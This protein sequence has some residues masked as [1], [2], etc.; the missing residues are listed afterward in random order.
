MRIAITGASGLIGQETAQLL[1][2]LGHSIL[3][4]GRDERILQKIFTD[5]IDIATTN[6]EVEDLGNKLLNIDAI[7]HLA[8][9]RQTNIEQDFTPYIE[10]NLILTENLLK[11]CRRNNIQTFC[12]TSGIAVYSEKNTSPYREDQQLSP[13]NPYGISKLTA[14]HLINM[15]MSQQ[16]SR[17]IILRLPKVFGAA[18]Q[19]EKHFILTRFIS[20]AIKKRETGCL[21]NRKNNPRF[22]LCERHCQGNCKSIGN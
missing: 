22:N 13:D 2:S 17:S 15:Y 7:V 10:G 21:G 19:S 12:F 20:Q 11:I 6:Y 16:D 8:A 1:S 5:P 9:V 4:L 14:E 3:A 18:D